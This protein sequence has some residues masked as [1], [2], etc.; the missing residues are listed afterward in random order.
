MALVGPETE[1][2]VS[3]QAAESRYPALPGFHKRNRELVYAMIDAG[4]TGRITSK[5]HFLAKAPDGKTTITVPSKDG[6]N[7][8]IANAHAQFMR[9]V[10]EHVTPEIKQLWDT[11]V[12]TDDPLVKDVLA[13]S[14]VKKQTEQIMEEQQARAAKQ[15]LD[16]WNALIKGDT[17]VMYEPLIRPWLARK[18]P[19]KDGGTRYE[20]E[21]VLERVWPDGK[22]DYACFAQGCPYTSNNPRGVAAHYGKA[23]T[24]KGET[25]PAEVGPLHLDPSYTEPTTTRDYRPTQRL[26][27]A[28]KAVLDGVVGQ[29]TEQAAIAILTWMHERP[30]ISHEERPPV[31]L[32]DRQVLDK[33]R[34]L[35]GQPDQSEEIAALK[36]ENLDLANQI[37]RLQ[38]ERAALRELLS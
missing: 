19:G 17:R 13:D 33:I 9:W 29:D 1:T 2:A 35:V 15:F 12:E 21:A 4:W 30:D 24:M 11:A 7:R 14:I 38:E 27:D 37:T 31:P 28:L 6:N 16:D 36:A 8:G 3:A 5:Q 22:V 26:V 20:S 25:P 32:T 23:H 18:Q 34:M 10:K